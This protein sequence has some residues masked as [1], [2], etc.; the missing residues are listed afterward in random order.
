MLNLNPFRQSSVNI[1]SPDEY[2]YSPQNALCQYTFSGP[3]GAIEP[4]TVPYTDSNS[5]Q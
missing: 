3:L 2:V 4:S 1:Y 5:F